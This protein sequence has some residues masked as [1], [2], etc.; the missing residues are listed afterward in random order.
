MA[1]S[2]SLLQTVKRSGKR[3]S[4]PVGRASVKMFIL[5]VA[6][7][8]Y[9]VQLSAVEHWISCCIEQQWF[10][11]NLGSCDAVVRTAYARPTTRYSF[12]MPDVRFSPDELRPKRLLSCAASSIENRPVEYRSWGIKYASIL[13]VR[14]VHSCMMNACCVDIEFSTAWCNIWIQN[15]LESRFS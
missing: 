2:V 10:W 3:T 9:F 13:I 7:K 5:N 15:T 8:F 4:D 12:I 6:S 14:L 1:S 11:R